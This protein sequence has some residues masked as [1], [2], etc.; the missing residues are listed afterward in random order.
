[1]NWLGPHTFVFDYKLPKCDTPCQAHVG[2]FYREE[3]DT[4]CVMLEKVCIEY[5]NKQ[6]TLTDV[7]SQEVMDTIDKAAQSTFATFL[8]KGQS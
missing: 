5:G 7:L 3:S 2:V 6:W 1:M 4:Y 8:Q